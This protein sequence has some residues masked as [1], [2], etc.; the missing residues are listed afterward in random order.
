MEFFRQECWRGLPFLSP[1][2]LPESKIE[3]GSPAMQAGSLPTEPPRKP[4]S[5]LNHPKQPSPLLFLF[6]LLFFF[7]FI[8]WFFSFTEIPNSIVIF[9]SV[10]VNSQVTFLPVVIRSGPLGCLLLHVSHKETFSAHKRKTGLNSAAVMLCGC[11]A[12]LVKFLY[13]T[14]FLCQSIENQG[15]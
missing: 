5:H 14:R 2:D 12:L 6:Y 4:V 7:F 9:P 8:Y 10:T 1:G 13:F 3:P 15:K 11:Y